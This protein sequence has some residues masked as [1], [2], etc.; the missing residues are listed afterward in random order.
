MSIQELLNKVD[1]GMLQPRDIKKTS[2]IG[3]YVSLGDGSPYYKR[4]GTYA[5]R[6]LTADEKQRLMR[7]IPEHQQEELLSVE[8]I[9]AQN[10]WDDIPGKGHDGKCAYLVHEFRLPKSVV[11]QTG[12]VLTWEHVAYHVWTAENH[13]TGHWMRRE[14]SIYQGEG[15]P[16]MIR[17]DVR[18][19]YP[20][21]SLVALDFSE[22]DMLGD[23]Q[24][25]YHALLWH[26]GENKA[27][28]VHYV[29]EKYAEMDV[30]LEDGSEWALSEQTELHET[31]KARLAKW[32]AKNEKQRPA[33]KRGSG[34]FTEEEIDLE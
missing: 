18:K 6:L 11:K 4:P 16:E 29:Q 13:D 31:T 12:I 3:F 33:I 23:S 15:Q 1:I 8:D 2:D 24:Y 17:R 20:E 32:L 27:L 26:P 22:G 19:R 7:A 5:A 25:W 30:R 10:I 9:A 34:S 14:I 28:L 21:Y